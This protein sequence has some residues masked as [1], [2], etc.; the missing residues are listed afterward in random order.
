MNNLLQ[1]G[2]N[3]LS[4]SIKNEYLSYNIL[5]QFE[6]TNYFIDIM[7]ENSI[8]FIDIISPTNIIYDSKYISINKTYLNY[9][10]GEPYKDD[11][12]RINPT[13]FLLRYKTINHGLGDNEILYD[14]ENNTFCHIFNMDD[15]NNNNKTKPAL[16]RLCLLLINQI[17]AN[18]NS[19]SSN[20]AT[21]CFK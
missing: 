5:T 1:N 17:N 11:W 8:D 15:E 19:Q 4:L 10:I 13:Q 9:S 3:E 20:N 18:D 7:D 14:T 16:R 21:I 2:F 6:R 12:I